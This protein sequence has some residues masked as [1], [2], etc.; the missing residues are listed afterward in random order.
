MIGKLLLAALLAAQTAL[1]GTDAPAPEQTTVLQWKM[2]LDARGRLEFRAGNPEWRKSCH[3]NTAF[4]PDCLD[5]LSGW[6]V[7]FRSG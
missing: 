7:L 5:P 3:G 1:T 4:R 6:T 2:S